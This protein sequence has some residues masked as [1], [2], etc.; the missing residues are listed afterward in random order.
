MFTINLCITEK[1]S[2]TQELAGKTQN[3]SNSRVTMPIR[4]ILLLKLCQNKNTS[5]IAYYHQTSLQR[6]SFD[7][8][9]YHIQTHS[10]S[11]SINQT[12]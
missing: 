5:I 8:F 10:Y 6:K 11:E 2:C 4:E 9:Y 12:L 3:I 1:V 7:H